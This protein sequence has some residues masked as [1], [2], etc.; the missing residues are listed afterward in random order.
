[1]PKPATST[2]PPAPRPT[3]AELEILQALWR[4]GPS[5]VRGVLDHLGSRTGYTTVLKIMQIMHEKGLV[6]RDERGRTHVYRPAQPEAQ[7]QR[8]L[9]AD[10]INRAFG[11][12]ARKLVAAALSARRATPQELDEIRKLLDE[13]KGA[14]P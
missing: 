13:M 2:A 1:M 9:A 6:S 3:E 14:K 10:L 5:T 12:S 8:R 11:G 4:L 7:T